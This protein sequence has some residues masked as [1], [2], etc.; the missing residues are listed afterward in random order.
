MT[1][2]NNLM[3]ILSNYKSNPLFARAQQMADGKSET[4]IQ[5]IVQNLC[6]EKGVDIN[7]ALD[8]FRQI[9]SLFK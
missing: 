3:G 7:Q 4:E 9:Q 6:K 8:Q 2:Q 1:N 5:Q